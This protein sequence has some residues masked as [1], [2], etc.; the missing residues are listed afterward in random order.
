[1]IDFVE[2]YLSMMCNKCK[3]KKS[4]VSKFTHLK[5]LIIIVTCKKIFND[6]LASTHHCNNI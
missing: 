5:E 6:R 4:K 2:N 1:M 3:K